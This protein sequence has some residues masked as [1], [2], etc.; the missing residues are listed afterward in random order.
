LVLPPPPELG[1]VAAG[2]IARWVVARDDETLPVG[3]LGRRQPT[4][5]QAAELSTAGTEV[6][7][8][9]GSGSVCF[10]RGTQCWSVAGDRASFIV[11]DGSSPQSCSWMVLKCE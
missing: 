9:L 8:R 4:L 7:A 3:V 1:A 5:R 2:L 10:R 11:S 6:M